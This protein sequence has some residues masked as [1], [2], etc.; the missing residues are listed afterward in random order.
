MVTSVKNHDVFS[1]LS[2]LFNNNACFSICPIRKRY[3]NDTQKL[4]YQAVFVLYP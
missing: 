1:F 2:Y 4:A 3:A